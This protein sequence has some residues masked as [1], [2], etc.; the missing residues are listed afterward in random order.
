MVCLTDSAAPLLI[1]IDEERAVAISIMV[2]V[3][4]SMSPAIASPTFAVLRL[5]LL[6]EVEIVVNLVLDE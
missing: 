6:V 5:G 4:S 2:S 3:G 1:L